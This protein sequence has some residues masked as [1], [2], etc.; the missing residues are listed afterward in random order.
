MVIAVLLASLLGVAFRV[1]KVKASGTIYIRADGSIDPPTANITTVDDVTYTFTNNNYD[2]IVVE[3][4]DIVVDGAGYTV[5]GT[6][7]LDSKGIYLSGVSNVT[8]KNVNIKHFY[9]GIYLYESSNNVL[10]GNNV[11]NNWYG[12][13]LT[14]SSNSTLSGNNVTAN[15]YNGIFLD[16]SSDNTLSGNVMGNNQ[17]NFGVAGDE[18]SHYLRSVDTSNLVDGKPVYYFMNQSDMVVNADA[19]PGLGTWA[20]LTVPT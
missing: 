15:Y 12:I 11:A 3:R 2:S 16:H 14:Y 4:N 10:S 8:I 18:L 13:E 17:W 20:L 1:E 7:A 6:E 19:Y 9:Y 5:E